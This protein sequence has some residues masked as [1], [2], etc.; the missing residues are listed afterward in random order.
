MGYIRFI[1]TTIVQPTFHNELTQRIELTPWDLQLIL[2]DHIQKG[3]L[4]HK[5]K[6]STYEQDPITSLTE[7]LKHSLSLTLDIFYPLAGRL[8][9][10]ENE[11]DNTTSFSVDCNGAGAEFVH[12]VA[13]GVTVADILDSVL[14]P[15]DI[16][17]S[18]F[19][20]NGVLNYEGS[21]S[22]PL[23][24]VQITE[25]VDGIF[26]GCT[27]NHSVV[28]GSSFWHFFN[29]WSEISRRGSTNCGKILQPPPAFGR[30][31]LNG[32]IDLPVR[33][34]NFQNKIPKIRFLAPLLQQRV[35]HFSKQKIAQL[36][37]KANAEMGTTRISSLQALLAHLWVSVTRNQRLETDQET[38]YKVLVGMR[39]RLQPPLP[40]QYLG[41]AVLFG[42][43]RTVTMK[44]GEVL[45]RGLGFVAWEMNNMVALQTEEKL[46]S[47]LECWVQE[48][49][50][51]TEDNMA[52]NALV[53]SS[54]PRFNVNG[55]DFGWER[56]VGVRNGVE[57]KSHGKITVFAGVEEGSIDIEAC[58]LAETLEAMGNDSEFMDVDTV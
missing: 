55:N 21:G 11:D 39:Q 6:S 1:S 3:L 45:E 56:P 23:L 34:P 30:D 40:D 50:L 35:F 33:L 28:D 54:S 24:A 42:I 15:D 44:A 41:N 27:M 18:F 52:A 29:T 53:T 38:Q 32:I 4:F 9:I 47:F 16:V 51:L 2:L 43:S 36:K 22:K 49:K 48:P 25:L 14:V 19:L 10:T 46:R 17:H 20:M 8:A 13:D 57:N 58:L 12:A 5:P 26:I 31:F 37:A 7:H